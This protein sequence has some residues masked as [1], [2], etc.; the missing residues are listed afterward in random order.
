MFDPVTHPNAPW[1]RTFTA[2]APA[3]S[4]QKTLLL[5]AGAKRY[6]AVIEDLDNQQLR[7]LESEEITA[8]VTDLKAGTWYK[9]SVT[10]VGDL[11]VTNTDPN[12]SVRRQT[13]KDINNNFSRL[14]LRAACQCE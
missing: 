9:F 11:N 14:C 5:C 6:Q 13:G 1:S 7:S 3:K 4:I 10:S 12:T 2:N 8:L